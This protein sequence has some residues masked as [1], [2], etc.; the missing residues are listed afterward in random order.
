M[1]ISNKFS[2]GQ[3]EH[4]ISSKKIK[5]IVQGAVYLAITFTKDNARLWSEENKQ[6]LSL[7]CL[8]I[9]YS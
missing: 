2:Y 7:H 6:Q 5:V 9:L 8:C 1:M 4:N 3:I